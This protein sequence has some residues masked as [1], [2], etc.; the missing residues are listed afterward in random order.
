MAVFADTGSSRYDIDGRF[1]DSEPLGNAKL[2]SSRYYIILAAERI[3][4]EGDLTEERTL[5]ILAALQ[6]SRSLGADENPAW[7]PTALIVQ[8]LDHEQ[9]GQYSRSSPGL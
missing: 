6:R 2:N 9:L 1:I 8:G 5:E 7:T 4:G 3:L